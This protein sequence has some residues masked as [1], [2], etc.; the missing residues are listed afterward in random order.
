MSETDKIT[1][2]ELLM[3]AL[4]TVS[5]EVLDVVELRKKKSYAKEKLI[6]K[7]EGDWKNSKYVYG[8]SAMIACIHEIDEFLRT[9]NE[10]LDEI[11]TL[12]CYLN[13]ERNIIGT[14]INLRESNMYHEIVENID[15]Q[16]ITTRKVKQKSDFW[17]ERRKEA[18]VTGSTIFQAIGLDGLQKQKEH[19]DAVVCGVEK[20]RTKNVENA[21]QYGTDNEPNVAATF[22][23]KVMPLLFPGKYFCEEGFIEKDNSAG[24][25]FMIISPDGSVRTDFNENSTIASV[26]FKCPMNDIHSKLPI[27][28][29]LQ[30]LS[31]TEVLDVE[32]LLYLSWR[33]DFSSLF[34]VKRN[35]PLFNQAYMLAQK[36]YEKDVPIR[37]TKT[38]DE[39]KG[40][41][42]AVQG[43]C[44]FDETVE[45]L[46]LI[47]SL[48]HDPAYQN[49]YKN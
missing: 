4:K 5:N 29:V 14:K 26:E 33:P 16:E 10:L 48:A 12:L 11:I 9:G 19:F 41:K 27:R 42:A 39:I 2:K 22:V 20:S 36:L 43:A 49:K 30:C 31:E 21:L 3:T 44:V 8:I 6:E 34:N 47:P 7:S 17:F 35:T 37:P 1:V 45:F 40:I 24:K 28:Y 32:L 23:G 15:S 25:P 46:G 38:N 13:E 18:K